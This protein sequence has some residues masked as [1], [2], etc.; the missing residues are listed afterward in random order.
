[1]QSLYRLVS[2]LKENPERNLIVEG[3]TDSIGS[4]SANL[5]LSESRANAVRDFLLAN[6]IASPRVFARGY[7]KAFPVA[8]N[9]S[10]GGRQIN[11]RVEVV[12]LAPGEQPE[13]RMRPSAVSAPPPR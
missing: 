7:G 9:D 1:M 2:Y 5:A 11:R 4:E 13:G 6:G 12:I 10:A 3:H 8:S